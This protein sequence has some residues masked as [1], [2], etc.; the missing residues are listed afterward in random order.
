[1]KNLSAF[2]ISGARSTSGN[3]GGKTAEQKFDFKGFLTSLSIVILV[4]L[5]IYTGFD[6]LLGYQEY[7]RMMH[8]QIIPREVLPILVP[9][10]PVLE[11][12]IAILLILP[13]KRLLGLYCSL[14]LMSVFTA[15]TLLVYLDFFP[16]RPCACAGL[17]QKMGWG[18]HV[19]VNSFLTL[20]A[21]FAIIM[22]RFRRKEVVHQK[23]V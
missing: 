19:L 9:G 17:F 10:L 8:L 7:W 22:H 20:V 11:I 16:A 13:S 12:T 14:L 5:W 2:N 6:K 15:Y 23:I 18:M 21:V 1:M 4:F 3:E